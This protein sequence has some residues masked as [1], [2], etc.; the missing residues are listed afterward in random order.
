MLALARKK[1]LYISRDKTAI[2]SHFRGTVVSI[3]PVSIAYN[4]LLA[5]HLNYEG[6]LA[7]GKDKG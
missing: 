1:P 5:F 3:A 6:N 2:K 4:E 7:G